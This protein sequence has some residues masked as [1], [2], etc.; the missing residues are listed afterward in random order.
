MQALLTLREE[1][2][3][4]GKMRMS[5]HTP[6]IVVL[7]LFLAVAL[8]NLG[9]APVPCEPACLLALRPRNQVS[10]PLDILGPSQLS[11]L[12]TFLST[13]VQ[14]ETQRNLGPP[15]GQSLPRGYPL[16]GGTL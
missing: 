5:P 16:L 13:V 1:T 9:R 6:T 4:S 8:G 15:W 7:V 12:F 14:G 11:T 10:K 2:G 3:G